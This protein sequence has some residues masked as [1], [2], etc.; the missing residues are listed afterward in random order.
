MKIKCVLIGALSVAFLTGCGSK[1][2]LLQQAKDLNP[3]FV[4]SIYEYQQVEGYGRVPQLAVSEEKCKEMKQLRDAVLNFARED[5]VVDR[6]DNPLLT[7][8]WNNPKKILEE[9]Q[10]VNGVGDIYNLGIYLYSVERAEQLFQMLEGL[11]YE[12]LSGIFQ[13]EVKKAE[14]KKSSFYDYSVVRRGVSFDISCQMDEDYDNFMIYME[15][16]Q[17]VITCPVEYMDLIN[18]CV[19]D[20]LFLAKIA[21][22]GYVECLTFQ[23]SVSSPEDA[24]NK[25]I[26]CYIKDGKL[27]QMEIFM[28][29]NPRRKSTDVFAEKEGE[30]VAKMLSYFTGDENASRTFVSGFKPGKEKSGTIGSYTWTVENKGG[31]LTGN[32][33]FVVRIQ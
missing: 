15:V 14:K 22:G 32:N 21:T 19:K 13:D 25:Q 10:S 16:P 1:D 5:E 3:E 8:K 23:G 27:L 7:E 18:N 26:D 29:Q 11:G 20:G 9:V 6:E 17:G 4:S 31:G 30:S 24:Y 33:N 12:D 28:S 2:V